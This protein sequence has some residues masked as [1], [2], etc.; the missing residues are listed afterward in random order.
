MLETPKAFQLH[1]PLKQPPFQWRK[2]LAGGFNHSKKMLQVNGDHGPQCS[3]KESKDWKSPSSLRLWCLIRVSL[4]H[5]S[6][7]WFKPQMEVSW[8]WGTQII[9]VIG[10]WLSLETHGDLGIPHGSPAPT[11]PLGQLCLSTTGATAGAAGAAL[12]PGDFQKFPDFFQI[13]N[14][15]FHVLF[16]WWVNGF[17]L[18]RWLPPMF[19]HS[20]KQSTKQVLKSIQIAP[21]FHCEVGPLSVG[22][23][24]DCS[25]PGTGFVCKIRGKLKTQLV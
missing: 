2:C 10:P 23:Q 11:W 5:F 13:A 24:L 7:W 4:H 21:S 9:Q 20:F 17:Q 3:S 6:H 22:C 18:V 25:C 1:V 16:P 19:S 14:M 15:N 12:G 8:N